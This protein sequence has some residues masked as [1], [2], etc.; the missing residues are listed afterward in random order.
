MNVATSA[1]F[2]LS[3]V[4]AAIIG[5]ARFQQI[6]PVFFPFIYLVWAGLL[7]E[8]LSLMLMYNGRSNILNYNVYA[9]V[10][11]LIVCQQFYRWKLASRNFMIFATGLLSAIWLGEVIQSA[12]SKFVSY[13]VI[14]SSFFIVLAGIS[15]VNKMLFRNIRSGNNRPVLLICFAFIAYFS[16]SALT[17]IFW[18]FGLLR[19]KAFRLHIQSLMS[20]INLLTNLAYAVA[21]LWIPSKLRFFQLC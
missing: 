18:S 5:K 3:I 2:S 16:F 8:I 10:E 20:L 14:C 4:L 11:V 17:E 1:I 21:I 7:N 13:F 19:S 9:L 12:N 6:N 15:T